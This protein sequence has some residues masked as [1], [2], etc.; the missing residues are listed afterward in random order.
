M[1]AQSYQK[2]SNIK[3]SIKYY[4]IALK[5]NPNFLDA[6]IMLAETYQE[7]KNFKQS[8]KYF[9]QALKF[10]KNNYS[11]YQNLSI[12]YDYQFQT[13]KAI[14][15]IKK[16]LNLKQ[17]DT[18]L[19]HNLGQY[20]KRVD[21]IDDAI[22]TLKYAISLSDEN[23]LKFSLAMIF[24]LKG[25]LEDGFKLYEYRDRLRDLPKLTPNIN[26]KDKT[27]FIYL[28]QGYGD[29]FMFM[30]FI[31][32]LHKQGAKI[33]CEYKDELKDIFFRSL[34]K[35]VYKFVKF[36]QNHNIK[37]N[38]AV[39]IMSLP[40]VLQVKN[41][42]QIQ[43]KSYIKC[44]K[45]NSLINSSKLKVGVVWA[46]SS[47]YKDDFRRSIKFK[48]FKELFELKE[49][50]FYSLQIDKEKEHINSSKIPNL[51]DLSSY[52]NDFSDSANLIQ[53]LDIIITVDTSIAHLSGAL[54]QKTW[55][56]LP[57]FPD[58]R[59]QIKSKET[60]WYKSTKIFRQSSRQDWSEVIIN[61]KKKLHS[62]I[63]GNNP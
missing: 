8:K 14:K 53:N 20:Y 31:P 22:N 33:I 51:Y 36:G 49:I 2:L 62:I 63:K 61:V 59:W 1:I 16:A 47:E 21:R 54:G 40:Y 46:G 32:L 37:Y 56:L 13:K 38:Y 44:K 28:E 4:K 26:V 9:K 18:K 39:S 24:L 58:W 42:Y 6:I 41:D 27:I 23:V 48:D 10:D 34:K 11:I 25:N 60:R 15:Y 3:K 43:K 29:I 45:Q 50:D 57:Y 12:I 52:I 30:R 7:I 35:D 19:L 5:S 55:L 17:N